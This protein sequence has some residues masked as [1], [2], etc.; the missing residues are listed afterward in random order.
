MDFSK[1]FSSKDSTSSAPRK[2][3]PQGY[4]LTI[5]N[6]VCTAWAGQTN[7]SMVEIAES[8]HGR[9]A[10]KLFPACVSRCRETACVNIVFSTGQLLVTGAK[11]TEIGRV[12]AHMFVD[13]INQDLGYWLQVVNF[14]I[15]NIV[16]SFGLGFELNLDLFYSRHKPYSQWDPETFKGLRWTPTLP[17]LST[18]TF[19]LFD[20]GKCVLTGGRKES[21]LSDAYNQVLS[22]LEQY[23]LGEE[24]FEIEEQHKRSRAAYQTSEPSKKKSKK[25]KITET[26][27]CG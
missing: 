14:Q 4:P 13:R 18:L 11:S 25:K 16:G 19:V 27:V 15:V 7:L 9:L 12:S 24:L 10:Q 6:I 26:N 17:G 21:D 5:Q 1:I 3:N 23:K 8:L 2:R 20:T 22:Y